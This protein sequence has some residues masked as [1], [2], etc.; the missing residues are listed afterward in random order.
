MSEPYNPLDMQN[1]GESIVSAFEGSDC[2]PLPP[3]ERADG[4]GIY[5]LYYTGA[6]DAYAPISNPDCRT[7]IYV[8]KAEPRGRRIGTGGLHEEAGP[9]VFA[10]LQKHEAS[11]EAAENLNLAD[12]RCRHLIVAS[13]WIPLG[14]SLLIR[15]FRPV[16][17]SISGF[18]LNDPGAGR[19]G[20][21][22]SEWDELHP[23]RSWYEK[24]RRTRSADDV[25][26]RIAQHFESH[27][28][29]D[30]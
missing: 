18:G 14:E 2:Q 30:S 17:N 26:E 24:M 10:R 11:V 8:G 25:R 21:A 28:E 19:Y 7:P 3:A 15:H 16:W 4:A 22:R 12:F 6:F 20:S 1:L 23:G 9:Y 29:P 27:A 5:A 13:I